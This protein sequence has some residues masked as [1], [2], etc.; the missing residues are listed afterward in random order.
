M[1]SAVYNLAIPNML[2]C[3]LRSGSSPTAA[4]RISFLVLGLAVGVYAADWNGPEQELAR[5][6]ASVTGP[7]AVALTV[8]NRSSL[9]RRDS[10]IITNGLRAAL[11][12]AGLRLVKPEQAAAMRRRFDVEPPLRRLG[13]G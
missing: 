6:V 5:K 10:A 13:A 4:L 1:P 8:E 2:N 3:P 7:G 9:G 12:A 11:G